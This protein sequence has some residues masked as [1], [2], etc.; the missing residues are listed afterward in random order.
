MM[1]DEKLRYFTILIPT[2]NNLSYLKL[3][4]DSIRKNSRFNHQIVLHINEGVDGTLEW[5]A[6]EG[7]QYTHSSENVGVCWALNNAAQLAET[8]YIAY[9]N[10]DMYV[11]PDWD[12]FLVKEIESLPDDMFFLSS[13]MIEPTGGDNPCVIFDPRFGDS[14]ET[15][16]EVGLLAA[17]QSMVKHDWCGATWPPNVV[18]RRVW[19]M[20]G[21]YSVEYFP[22]FGSD[23]DFSRKLWEL[24]VRVFKGVGESKVYHFQCKSTGRVKRND[25]KL[26]F[27]RK[28]GLSVADFWQDYLCNGQD[29]KGPLKG[30]SVTKSLSLKEKFRRG[31]KD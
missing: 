12:A 21:G 10:D 24:G 27:L 4:V 8:D 30:P 28:W 18:S 19:Q 17:H 31:F 9:M 29:Y 1:K 23:P 26:Q 7:I 25:G 6:N 5:A 13:T 16:D 15:F 14:L 3:C 11:L 22:G 2:W 20:V